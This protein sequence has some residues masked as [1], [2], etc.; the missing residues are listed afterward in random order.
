MTPY[1]THTQPAGE[2]IS[3]I[4]LCIRPGRGLSQYHSP[5]HANTGRL[6]IGMPSQRSSP[7]GSFRSARLL[8]SHVPPGRPILWTHPAQSSSWS[9]RMP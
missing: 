1:L 7:L 2:D 9:A 5:T 3:R 4:D 6:K 8:S